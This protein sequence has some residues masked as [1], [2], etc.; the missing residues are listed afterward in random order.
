MKRVFVMPTDLEAL[1]RGQ[2]VGAM[3]SENGQ[4]RLTKI[5]LVNGKYHVVGNNGTCR[6][7][8]GVIRY[9]KPDG[10]FLRLTEKEDKQLSTLKDGETMIVY[11]SSGAIVINGDTKS[12]L[13]RKEQV[14]Q[15]NAR[16]I[17][18][19][20]KGEIVNDTGSSVLI[21]EQVELA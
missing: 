8:D 14:E 5:K 2:V 18:I 16:Q 21:L 9:Q 3:Y 1:K 13:T 19:N 17:T 15:G 4:A 12:V 11:R 10:N 20:H 7:Y 6:A